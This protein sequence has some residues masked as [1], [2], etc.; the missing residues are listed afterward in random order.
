M[1]SGSGTITPLTTS[2][3]YATLADFKAWI[4]SR[5]LSGTVGSDTSDDTV[6]SS[7]LEAASR[8]VDNQTGRRFYQDASDTDY[9][10]SGQDE[11]SRVMLPDFASITTVS[12]DYTDTRTYTALTATDFDTLPDNAAAEGL[13]FTG[14]EVAPTSL[15]ASY[16]PDWRKSVKVT[17]KRGWPAVPADIRDAVLAICESL[18][19]NRSGQ[20]SSGKMTITAAG[21]VIRPEDVPPFA[22]KVIQQYRKM[23]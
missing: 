1:T 14:L 19:S 6:L 2:T 21:I 15:T 20:S 23:I 7:L 3:S 18:N 12:V 17:G 16:F 22:H 13:P 11:M 9:Y 5:G 10:Y 4:A 8:Y